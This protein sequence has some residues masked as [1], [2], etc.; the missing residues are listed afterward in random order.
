MKGICGLS[1][2][3]LLSQERISAL[4]VTEARIHLYSLA[5]IILAMECGFMAVDVPTENGRGIFVTASFLCFFGYFVLECTI[6]KFTSLKLVSVLSVLPGLILF[7]LLVTN[8]YVYIAS[9]VLLSVI[10]RFVFSYTLTQ[11]LHL[12]PS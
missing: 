2:K 1:L 9:A 12:T 6:R 5:M 8:G 11:V 7:A 10:I 4:F 3:R